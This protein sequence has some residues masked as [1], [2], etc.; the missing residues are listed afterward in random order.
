MEGPKSKKDASEEGH[1]RESPSMITSEE[2]ASKR[3]ERDLKGEEKDLN[4]GIAWAPKLLQFIRILNI[5]VSREM[6]SRSLHD[7]QVASRDG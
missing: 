1:R 3:K 5:L 6:K 4:V 2:R 7:Q